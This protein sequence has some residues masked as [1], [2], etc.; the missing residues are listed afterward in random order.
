MISTEDMLSMVLV[1]ESKK[2]TKRHF[3]YSELVHLYIYVHVLT[4][5]TV[6]EVSEYIFE[7]ANLEKFTMILT[8]RKHVVA[9]VTVC[10]QVSQ[11]IW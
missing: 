4:H 8:Y 9:L 11:Q 1:I 2:I 5:L 6:A 10:E 3:W 7:W